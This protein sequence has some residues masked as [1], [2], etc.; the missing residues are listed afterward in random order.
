MTPMM[1]QYMSVKHK[2]PDCILFYRLGDFYE[3]FYEDALTAS[4]ELEIVLTQRDAG[5]GEKAPMCGVPYH[6]YESYLSKLVNK[7]YKVAICEQLEDPKTVKGIVKR[8]IVKIVTPGTIIDSSLVEKQNN[9]LCSIFLKGESCG[10][11][12]IDNSTGEL[13]ASEFNM[14]DTAQMLLNELGKISPPEIIINKEVEENSGFQRYTREYMPS[15]TLRDMTDIKPFE[16]LNSF[17]SDIEELKSKPYASFATLSA[18]EY[19]KEMQRSDFFHINKVNLY[20][21][22]QYMK[23]DHNTKSNLELTE[24]IFGRKRK[25]S[26]IHVLDQTLTAMGGRLLKK[27]IEYPLLSEEEINKRLD[28]VQFFLSKPKVL[29]SLREI[30]R[31]IYDLERI[32]SKISSGSGNA[33]DF[34][35][36][37]TSLEQ[38]PTLYSIFDLK[39]NPLMLNHIIAEFDSLADICTRIDKTIVDDPPTTTTEGG[40]IRPD[41][42]EELESLHKL[43]NG[44][45]TTILELE[46]REREKTGIR[47]LK[48]GF[49]KVYGYFFEV[50]NAQ[51]ENVPDY[52]IRRQTLTNCERY[53]TE[54]LKK[55]EEN[56]L[57]AGEKSKKLEY[58]IFLELREFIKEQI[59][60]IQ[61]MAKLVAMLDVLSS[62][63]KVSMENNYCRPTL[64]SEGRI[65]IEEGRHPVVETHLKEVQFISNDTKIGKDEKFFQIITGPN[66]SG[67][68]TYMRQVALITLLAHIGCYVPA[69]SAD[70]SITDRIFTRIGASDNLARGESTFMVEMKEVAQILNHATASSLVILDEVGRGTGTYD[71]LSIAWAIVEYMVRH[72]KAKTLFATHY[73]ELTQLSDTHDAIE[74]LTISILEKESGVV[75]LRKVVTGSTDQSYGIEVAKLA[76]INQEVTDKA[77]MILKMIEGSHKIIIN[78]ADLEEQVDK[79][80][81]FINYRKEYVFDSLLNTDLDSL[82]PREAHDLLYRLQQ[83]CKIIREA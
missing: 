76:G 54:E 46:N 17:F 53:F 72:L 79:Q 81:D 49:N 23:I 13:Y 63:A 44:G 50:T 57:H 37:R 45:K 22:N 21:P 31:S 25:G 52:F 40:M 33:R 48:I 55:L 69:T 15:I 43:L 75:F 28:A 27:W 77:Q 26:L 38:L 10:I 61:K 32:S 12:Y 3:M 73:H 4:R 78:K 64:N 71:G 51:R 5:N 8:D 1:E 19:L 82:S 9:F 18:M 6:V 35:S 59:H 7:G 41:F 58:E 74:N 68:S 62:F 16:K 14:Q 34:S 80:L 70:I 29:D 56:I 39:G 60:R 66:M 67:K 42:S 11:C 83:E 2:Y 36:L 47:N 24:T 65:E 30:L 20:E